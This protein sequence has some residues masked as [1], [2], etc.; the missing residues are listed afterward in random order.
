METSKIH[1]LWSVAALSITLA[2]PTVS[3]IAAETYFSDQGHTEVRFGWNHAGVSM[4]HGEFTKANAKLSL[5]PD[6]V[7]NSSIEATIDATSL[8]TGFEPLDKDL[9]SKNYLEVETYPQITFKSTSVKRTGDDTADI[10]GDLTIH[11][12]TQPVTL[13]AKLTHRGAHPVAK[14]IDYYKGQWIAFS[15]TTEIDHQAFK[16]GAFSTGPISIWISTE[17]KDRE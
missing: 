16:V 14:F 11:G 5:D 17:M 7:E 10:T 1:K 4:Q 8:S 9:K 6:N 2:L 15:A 13:K 3:A 12:V